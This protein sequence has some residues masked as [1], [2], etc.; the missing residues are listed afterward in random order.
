M[1]SL[2]LTLIRHG[3]TEYHDNKEKLEEFNVKLTPFGCLQS[4]LLSGNYD[5]IFVS[6]LLRTI[7]TFEH[8]RIR[9]QQILYDERIREYRTCV[10]DFIEGENIL[11]ENDTQIINRCLD[12]SNYLKINF[13]DKNICIFTHAN[14]IKYFTKVIGHPITK[15]P[16]YCEIL[17]RESQ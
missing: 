5:V 11:F 14:W 1:S 7:M 15:Y 10:C 4:S 8:S 9:G 2:N 13:H 3:E 16:N 6:P 17:F 12:F